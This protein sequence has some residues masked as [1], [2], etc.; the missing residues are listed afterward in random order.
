M[1]DPEADI[2]SPP[3]SQ[4]PMPSLPHV[5]L[6]TALGL[7]LFLR[8]PVLGITGAGMGREHAPNVGMPTPIP[9]LIRGFEGTGEGEA[10]QHLYG[11]CSWVREQEEAQ[12]N[13]FLR[14]ET[15]HGYSWLRASPA[16]PAADAPAQGSG[17]ATV[18][19]ANMRMSFS[20]SEDISLLIAVDMLGWRLFV[21]LETA[22]KPGWSSTPTTGVC[23][24]REQGTT[25]CQ[26][27]L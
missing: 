15:E 18:G 1:A 23:G 26:G 27:G 22:T 19:L 3:P 6:A 2:P 21:S 11:P 17:Q 13:P 14:G 9:E 12:T 4:S 25:L 7:G 5:Y 10:V 8:L 20:R 16:P 24:H